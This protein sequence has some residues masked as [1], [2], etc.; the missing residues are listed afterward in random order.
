MRELTRDELLYEIRDPDSHYPAAELLDQF[1]RQYVV[2]PKPELYRVIEDAVASWNHQ[3]L[4]RCFTE[5]NKALTALVAV[6]NNIR[7]SA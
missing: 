6:L 1:R 2:M 4:T 3:E 5:Y 7:G